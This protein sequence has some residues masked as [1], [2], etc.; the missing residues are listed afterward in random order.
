VSRR[1]AMLYGKREAT[2][3]LSERRRSNAWFHWKKL[4][5]SL[6]LPARVLNSAGTNL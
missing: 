2:N 4:K 5:V 3:A 1:A 6:D